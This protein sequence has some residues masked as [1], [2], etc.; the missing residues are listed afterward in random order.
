MIK[1]SIII[2]LFNKEE[3]VKN[4]I[5]SVLNQ[6]YQG[7]ELIIVNDGSTDNS[8][9]VVTEIKDE[10]IRI[11]NI[12]NGGVSNAR[13]YGI[14]VS[15]YEYIT[16]LDADDLWYENALEEF[17]YLI[18]NFTEAQVFFTSHTLNIK[19]I[20]SRTRRY[21]IDNFFKQNSISYARTT[22]AIC[23]TGCVAIK[24][25]CLNEICGFKTKLSHGEDIDLWERLSKRYKIAKSEVVTLLYRLDAENRSDKTNADLITKNIILIDK[26]KIIDKYEKL[27]WGRKYFF[28]LLQN[29]RDTKRLI[30][31]IRILIKYFDLISNF[32]WLII[33]YKLIR[34]L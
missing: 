10:R 31:N 19:S 4:T 5:Q 2:P 21:Y 9:E 8:L 17:K 16:F 15:N 13:N 23:C 22:T 11:Y 25:S 24:S 32:S 33:K 7:F 6:S 28:F 1:F 18:D 34:N 27:D 26:S 20:N 12:P 29:F 3:S 30:F 14:S